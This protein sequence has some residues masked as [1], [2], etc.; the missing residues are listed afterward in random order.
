MTDAGRKGPPPQPR[1][2]RLTIAAYERLTARARAHYD[3]AVEEDAR[4]RQAWAE[5]H[6]QK[7]K[8]S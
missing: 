6:A 8:Q 1:A 4:A 7:A 3:W 2:P 5:E